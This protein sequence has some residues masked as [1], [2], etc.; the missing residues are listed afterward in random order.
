[1]DQYLGYTVLT[2][3]PFSLFFYKYIRDLMPVLKLSVDYTQKLLLFFF[4]FFLFLLGLKEAVS[5]HGIWLLIE[6]YWEAVF[7]DTQEQKA[8]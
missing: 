8:V 5:L 7:A 3:T 2:K 4:L 1:M 6:R